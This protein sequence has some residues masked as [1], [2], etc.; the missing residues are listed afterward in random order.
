MAP[1]SS[2][3]VCDPISMDPFDAAQPAKPDGSFSFAFWAWVQNA[4]HSFC[5]G[6]VNSSQALFQIL[7][8]FPKLEYNEI[9]PYFRTPR[10]KQADKY[11]F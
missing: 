8:S 9:Q 5:D 10:G 4:D 1:Y 3:W 11:P 2:L 7:P 6:L